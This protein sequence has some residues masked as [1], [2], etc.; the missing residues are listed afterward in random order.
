MDREDRTLLI[1][2]DVDNSSPNDPTDGNKDRLLCLYDKHVLPWYCQ[3]AHEF[4]RQVYVL[5]P[6]RLQDQSKQVLCLLRDTSVIWY[7]DEGVGQFSPEGRRSDVWIVNGHQLPMVDWR[8]AGAAIRRRRT[9][10]LIFGQKGT[11]VT[12]HYPESVVVGSSGEVVRF[13]RHYSDSPAF[14]DVCFEEASFLVAGAEHATAVVNHVVA[15][16]WGLDS[17]GAMTRRFQVRWSPTGCVLWEAAVPGTTGSISGESFQKLQLDSDRQRPQEQDSLYSFP[18]NAN[19]GLDLYE[20]NDSTE[21]LGRDRD[22]IAFKTPTVPQTPSHADP[23]T[24]GSPVGNMTSSTHRG[25]SIE[26]AVAS[27]RVSPTLLQFASSAGQADHA[28]TDKRSYLLWKRV[29]DVVLTLIGVI[30]LS[31]LFA[32]VAI[33]I[34][35]TSAGPVFF[36][37]RRQGL[38]GKEF[39]CLKFRSMRTGADA[40]QDALR[41][42]NEVDGPQFKIEHDPRLTVLG[43]WL[44]QTN[45]DELPQLF[46]VLVGHMSLVGPRPSPDKENQLCPSWRRARLSVKPGVTGLWQVMRLRDQEQSD[47]QEWIYYDVEYARHQSLWLDWQIILYTPVSIF[48]SAWVKDLAKQL[49]RRGICSYSARIEEPPAA[50]PLERDLGRA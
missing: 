28:I 7:S 32:L 14:T 13:K 45:I 43:K 16:G 26:S 50:P 17:I 49:K 3:W 6:E 21:A 34:K 12:H 18:L 40:M 11:G 8:A 41:S 38:G 4:A 29:M 1:H 33:L 23:L 27:K 30:A 48:A 37:H 44:R 2:L 24:G 42:K 39:P 20:L 36:A 9:D 47:F 15:R 19:H 35:C 10:V 25:A 46:N 22:S 5:L 31:P